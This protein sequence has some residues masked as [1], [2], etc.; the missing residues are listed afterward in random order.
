M[1]VA[2]VVTLLS[3]GGGFVAYAMRVTRSVYLLLRRAVC[4][5]W[6]IT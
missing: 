6:W 4:M 2:G 1:G 3:C 5:R